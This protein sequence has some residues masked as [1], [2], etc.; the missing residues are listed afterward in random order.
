VQKW[1]KT[2]TDDDL[3]EKYGITRKEQVY[4]ESQVKG[5]KL[6]ECDDD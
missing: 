2:W 6:E 1:N 5:M 3:Y 4:I